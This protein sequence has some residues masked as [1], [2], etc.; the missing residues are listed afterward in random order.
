MGGGCAL[1]RA[2][3]IGCAE[4]L[5]VL[6]ITGRD[7]EGAGPVSTV[8]AATTAIPVAAIQDLGGSRFWKR[9]QN[10]EIQ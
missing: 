1:R 8:V 4:T 6:F 2:A 5:E 10:G 7:V 9:S 3:G